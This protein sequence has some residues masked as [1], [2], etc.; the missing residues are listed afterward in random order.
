MAVFPTIAAA[1]Y[2]I[3]TQP[4]YNGAVIHLM[5]NT[6][7]PYDW[8]SR[9]A[10]SR[11]FGLPNPE[12][13][14]MAELWMGSHPKAP[15]LL[16]PERTSLAD[17]IA[18]DP[19]ATLGDRVAGR[20]DRRLPFLF[21][22]LSA[23]Q[24]LSIQ[25]HPS[26]SVAR[27]GFEREEAAG[28]PIDARERNYRDRN[29]KPELLV[30]LTPFCALRGF[31]RSAEIEADCRLLGAD[32]LLAALDHG[33]EDE[34]L[35]AFFQR[36]LCLSPRRV[37]ELI[38]AA[39]SRAGAAAR[40]EW[41]RRLDEQRRGDV[42]ALGPLYLNLLELASGDAVYQEAGVLH[43]YLEGTG[44]EIMANSDN[45]LRG[46]MTG[47][48][49]DV[50]ELLRVGR[51]EPTPP[52]V[53]AGSS[54]GGPAD[55]HGCTVQRFAPPF[56]EFEVL[57]V[58]VN[59]GPCRLSDADGPQI[60]LCTSGSI[61]ATAASGDPVS[62]SPG[63]SAFVPASESVCELGGSGVAYIARVPLR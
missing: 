29:H 41:V 39:S 24:G 44:V 15:S 3:A 9:D 38:A 62:L 60:V 36:L 4:E 34:R 6:I 10:M 28:I 33:D 50:D 40:F 59:G 5:H 51:F 2:T 21:K 16:L 8:G 14:P 13:L 58:T 61:E 20:F 27:E 43:A 53:M 17:V 56:D 26:E 52:A 37:A 45:V 35:R 55:G 19:D 25:A 57:R 31:R 23:A 32:E 7:Q 1:V 63:A 47:K 48:H 11:L 42:G 46:G 30:A 54:V 49:I 22:V 18:A 12:D